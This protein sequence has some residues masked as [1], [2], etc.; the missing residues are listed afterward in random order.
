[1][2]A[3]QCKA[4]RALLGWTQGDLAQHAAL[5]VVTI[6]DFERKRYDTPRRGTVALIQRAF[7]DAGLELDQDGTLGV[8]FANGTP[9]T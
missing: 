3:R 2:D 5:G 1:M 8:R 7:Q 6:R 4:A 9:L